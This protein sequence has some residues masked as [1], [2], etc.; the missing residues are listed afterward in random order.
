MSKVL[1]KPVRYA[2]KSRDVCIQ[3]WRE[4]YMKFKNQALKSFLGTLLEKRCIKDT[5]VT[6]EI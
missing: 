3:Y 4:K 5:I 6:D 2:V 1:S